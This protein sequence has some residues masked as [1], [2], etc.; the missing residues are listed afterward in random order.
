LGEQHLALL[1]KT[2]QVIDQLLSVLADLRNDY[3]C[4]QQQKGD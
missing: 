1:R 2:D 3:Q 4:R